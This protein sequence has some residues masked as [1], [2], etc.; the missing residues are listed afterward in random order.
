VGTL[1]ELA[2]TEAVWSDRCH[3]WG[4][5][6]RLTAAIASILVSARPA[7]LHNELHKKGDGDDDYRNDYLLHF[8][9][10]P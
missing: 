9:I 10:T 7:P 3:Q 4:E 1:H 2:A 8:A 5:A 6:E